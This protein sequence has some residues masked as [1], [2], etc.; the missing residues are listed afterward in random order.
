MNATY[1]VLINVSN[2]ILKPGISYTK[3][4]T[5]FLELILSYVTTAIF[6][7]IRE[8]CKELILLLHFVYMQ[9]CSNELPIINCAT[10]V[11]ICLMFSLNLLKLRCSQ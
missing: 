4:L 3:F 6:V 7:K 2:N 5:C 9:S 1:V 10:V 8:S 11:D